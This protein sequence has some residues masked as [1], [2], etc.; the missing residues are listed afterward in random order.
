MKQKTRRTFLKELGATAGAALTLPT[1]VSS[2][3]LGQYAPSNRIT[4][5]CIGMGS[6]GVQAN[7]RTFLY[8]ADAQVVA[9]CDA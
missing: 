2:H 8:Q 3:V 6:Q 7:L 4:L 5:G 1:I 9:V